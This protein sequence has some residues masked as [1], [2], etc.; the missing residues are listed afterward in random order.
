MRRKLGFAARIENVRDSRLLGCL[1]F[2]V[3]IEETPAQPVR[4][5]ASH[6]GFCRW[7]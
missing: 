4:Q 3:E 1:D 2:V 7:P 6:G 5:V